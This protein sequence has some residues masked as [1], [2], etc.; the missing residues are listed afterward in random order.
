MN[1][2]KVQTSFAIIEFVLFV[3][4]MLLYVLSLQHLALMIITGLISILSLV[5]LLYYLHYLLVEF[6]YLKLI[7]VLA[8]ILGVG[9]NM[10][11]CVRQLVAIIY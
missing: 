5:P 7:L 2:K 9:S 6:S 4:G 11:A 10:L 3:F 8:C 1:N